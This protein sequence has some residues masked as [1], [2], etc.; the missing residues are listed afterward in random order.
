MEERDPKT[1]LLVG[2]FLTVGLVLLGLL[3]LQFGSVKELFKHTYEITVPFAD[4]TGIKEGTPVM[5]GGS[6]VGKVPRRPAL[7]ANFNGVIIALEIYE[8]VLIPTDAK[9]GIGTA[10]LLGDSYIEIRP[11]GK[12]TKNYIQPG[13]ELTK[14]N[15]AGSSGMSALGDTAKEL[16]KSM[17]A[18]LVD[19][20]AAVGDLRVSLKKINE[21]AL[22]DAN[23]EELK[24]SFAHLNS[25]LTRLDEKT[26]GEETSKDVKEAVAAFKEA[27]KSLQES[28]KKLEPAFA[29]MDGVVAKA[30]TVMVSADKAMKSIDESA[31]A[32]G[33]VG[34]DLKKG[35]GLLPAL[36]HDKNLKNEFSML[37]TNLRQRGVLWYKDK[38]GEEQAAKPPLKR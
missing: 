23:M 18:A 26:L 12:E 15:V 22:A 16:S 17:D 31:A 20:R 2:L 21:G 8:H 13:T 9:F 38:A 36:I 25:V 33:K 1:E 27:A 10:G 37:I 11:T 35:E 34:T 30:D 14:D 29:K 5:L 28:T 24:G 6:K 4:G 32:L 19:I 7:N 3:I